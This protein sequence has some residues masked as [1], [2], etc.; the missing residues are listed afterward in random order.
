MRLWWEFNE[1]SKDQIRCSASINY[2]RKAWMKEILMKMCVAWMDKGIHGLPL[3]PILSALSCP[4]C[5]T[6][7]FLSL[8]STQ[9]ALI[10][11]QPGSLTDHPPPTLTVCTSGEK[12]EVHYA[13][14]RFQKRQ[15][16]NPQKQ[17]VT[18][19]EYSGVSIY[20]WEVAET[21]PWLD[22]GG[23]PQGK[24]EK[25]RWVPVKWKAI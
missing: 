15:P 19:N 1:T 24:E 11:P 18:D 16:G 20:N 2:L 13:S 3:P 17:Q 9:G 4:H 8:P 25:Q 21:W 22:D 12:E 5:L 10:E 7:S 14:L 6:L 23:P